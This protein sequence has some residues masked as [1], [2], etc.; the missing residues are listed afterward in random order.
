G[1]SRAV[2]CHRR[3]S[4]SGAH[5]GEGGP[6]ETGGQGADEGMSRP[7]HEYLKGQR[8]HPAP[9]E[10]SETVADLIDNAFLAYN[11]GRLRE[12][13]HLFTRRMLE[14]DVTVGMSLPGAMTP[15]GPGRGC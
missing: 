2:R 4:G 9:I 8:I 10:G 13:C 7:S 11:A 14:P 6:D 15:A 1:G 5:R 3:S 12:G